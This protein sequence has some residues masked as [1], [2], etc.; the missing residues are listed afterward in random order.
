M[1]KKNIIVG[2]I[3]I[4]L[5]LGGWGWRD[6]LH[7]NGISP[8][9]PRASTVIATSTVSYTNNQYGFTV[10]LPDSWQGYAIITS[11]WKGYS[12]SA[13][14][15]PSAYGSIISIRNPLWTSSTPT[16][17]IPIMIFTLAEWSAVSAGTMA[18]SAAPFPPSELGQN[19]QYVFAIPARY[20][21]A[22]PRGWQEVQTI[23]QGDPLHAF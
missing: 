10:S 11:T 5:V 22:F 17:D 14:S 9:A 21:Y 18:V 12:P 19:A 16:Q 1:D 15:G 3:A 23:I 8:S 2:L 6:K 13:D 7:T 4:M 20:N